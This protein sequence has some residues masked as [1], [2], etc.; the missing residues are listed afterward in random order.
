MIASTTLLNRIGQS[1]AQERGVHAITDV[2]GF[3]IL[4]HALEVARG[5]GF[6]GQNRME[7]LPWL[8]AQSLA[9]R[10]TSLARRGATGK[11]TASVDMPDGIEDWQRGLLTDPQTSGGLLVACAEDSAGRSAG[12]PRGRL[13][14]RQHHRRGD[15][16]TPPASKSTAEA[17]GDFW[18]KRMGVEPTKDRLAAPPGFEVRTPHRGRF[19]S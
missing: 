14:P 19:S 17:I 11:A 5:S 2:T 16:G 7:D 15:V 10:A 9:R 18:R 1:S 6:D 12:D 8:F 4:G 3:G 13:S